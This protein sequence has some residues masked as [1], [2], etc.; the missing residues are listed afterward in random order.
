MF[1]Q[2]RMHLTGSSS[3]I[4]KLGVAANFLFLNIVLTKSL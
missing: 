4:S 3:L 2:W 1:L